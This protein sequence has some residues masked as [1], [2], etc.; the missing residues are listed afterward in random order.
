MIGTHQQVSV[1]LNILYGVGTLQY[2]P[3]GNIFSGPFPVAGVAGGVAG[4]GVLVIVLVAMI[5][6]ISIVIYSRSSK[7]KNAQVASLLMQME[8]M[9]SAMADE[10]KRGGWAWLVLTWVR[11]YYSDRGYYK[12]LM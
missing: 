10:C 2:T 8:T 3:N 11:L 4:G 12:T 6:I 5:V 7:R 1:G 9:E